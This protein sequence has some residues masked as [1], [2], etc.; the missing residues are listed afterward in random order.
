M[1]AILHVYLEHECLSGGPAMGD[2]RDGFRGKAHT[3][4]RSST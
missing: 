2:C 4:E 1:I 3:N